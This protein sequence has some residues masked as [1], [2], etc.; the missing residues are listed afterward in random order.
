MEAEFS[1]CTIVIAGMARTFQLI[2]HSGESPDPP[3]MRQG[4]GEMDPGFRGTF[5]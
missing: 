3:I 4:G 5:A 1:G 2:P